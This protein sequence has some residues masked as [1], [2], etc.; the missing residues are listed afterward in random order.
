VKLEARCP[1]VGH[2][3]EFAEFFAASWDPCLRA[4]ASTDTPTLTM[5]QMLDPARSS[6]P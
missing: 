3:A 4:A 5:S 6:A 2:G 1:K